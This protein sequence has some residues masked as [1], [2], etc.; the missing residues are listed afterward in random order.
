MPYSDRICRPSCRLA[1]PDIPDKQ[2]SQHTCPLLLSGNLFPQT[3]QN[4]TIEMIITERK[5]SMHSIYRMTEPERRMPERGEKMT[6]IGVKLEMNPALIMK[7]S[8]GEKL[9]NATHDDGSKNRI[10]A[11]TVLQA[12]TYGTLFGVLTALFMWTRKKYRNRGKSKEDFDA[13]KEAAR[14]NRTCGALEVMLLEY[15]RSAQNGM[16]DEETL[17]ELIDTLEE[18]HGYDLAGKLQ[19]TNRED[20]TEIRK[21]ITKYTDAIAKSKSAQTTQETGMTETYE[22]DMIRD[23]LICQR[24]WIRQKPWAE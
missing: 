4:E 2:R 5:G 17:D 23:Q 9:W 19:I 14:I 21:G 18:M 10:D 3:E 11:D 7:I 22:F 24:E 12:G 15:I 13:E 20:L 1:S 6:E 16:I 8:S